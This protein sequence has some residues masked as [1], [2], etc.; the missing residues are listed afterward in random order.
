[1]D[2]KLDEM[3]EKEIKRADRDIVKY[4]VSLMIGVII[5]MLQILK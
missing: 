1:M 4:S 3:L 2:K 5:L